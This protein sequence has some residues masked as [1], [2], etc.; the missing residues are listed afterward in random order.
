MMRESATSTAD[1]IS[2]AHN[3]QWRALSG[4]QRRTTPKAANT[5]RLW[6]EGMEVIPVG[7]WPMLFN[8]PASNTPNGR[9]EATQDLSSGDRSEPSKKIFKLSAFPFKLKRVMTSKSSRAAPPS[10][11]WVMKD[12]KSSRPGVRWLSQSMACRFTVE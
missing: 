10:P 9:G 8:R 7:G 12:Q 4:K 11:N 3:G 2:S 1:T 5:V 6:P